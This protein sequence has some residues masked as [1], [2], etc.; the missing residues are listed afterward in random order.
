MENSNL[1]KYH[2]PHYVW[3]RGEEQ[4]FE[5]IQKAKNGL[6]EEDMKS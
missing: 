2:V 4:C 6:F 5:A 3:W 1:G